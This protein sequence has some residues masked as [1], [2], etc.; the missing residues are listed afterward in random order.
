MNSPG[1]HYGFVTIPGG[2]VPAFGIP[3]P[4]PGP[5]KPGPLGV[6]MGMPLPGP[7]GIGM[8][9]VE[10]PPGPPGPGM[11]AGPCRPDIGTLLPDMG[12]AGAGLKSIAGDAGMFPRMGMASTS[13]VIGMGCEPV[14]RPRA[15]LSLL[16][17][18]AGGGAVSFVSGV[19]MAP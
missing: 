16:P 9:M 14:F 19:I 3:A 18:F 2:G 15:P 12:G 1:I 10:G 13:G 8:D 7:L 6:G 17:A 5:F 4:G 11:A